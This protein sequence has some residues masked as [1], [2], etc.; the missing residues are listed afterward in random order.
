VPTPRGAGFSTKTGVFEGGGYMAKGIYS[1]MEDC[2]MKSNKPDVFC[3]VCQQAI[4]RAIQK[5]TE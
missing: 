1:P 4:T 2:R 3:P 5:N